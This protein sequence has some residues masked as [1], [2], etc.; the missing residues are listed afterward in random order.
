MIRFKYGVIIVKKGIIVF[1]S[2]LIVVLIV[3]VLYIR[4]TKVYKDDIQQL[5]MQIDQLDKELAKVTEISDKE[6]LVLKE[7]NQ[8]LKMQ[9]SQLN[10]ELAKAIGDKDINNDLLS[11]HNSIIK[12]NL[13][14]KENTDGLSYFPKQEYDGSYSIDNIYFS[15]SYIVKYL[16]SFKKLTTAL[17]NEITDELKDSIGNL[18]WDIQTLGFINHPQNVLVGVHEQNFIIKKLDYELAIKKFALNEINIDRLNEKKAI[19]LNSK[20]EFEEFTKNVVFAD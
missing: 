11:Q 17:V 7:E 6:A 14:I 8:Q 18:D 15:Y 3:Y 13:N 1:S 4:V 9:I 5:N 20:E 2:I 10:D 16:D 19:Y 12:Q